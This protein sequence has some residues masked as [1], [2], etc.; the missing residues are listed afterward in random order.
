L[1]IKGYLKIHIA[2]NIKSKKI[3][4]IPVTDENVYDSKALPELVDDIIKSDRK[5]TD[6]LFANDG[7]LI[8]MKFKIFVVWWSLFFH[9][10]K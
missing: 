7:T 9:T 4:S 8:V 10:S 3:L 2:V 5:I 1:N 6:N